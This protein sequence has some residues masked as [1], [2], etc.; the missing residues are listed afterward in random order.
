MEEV[1]KSWNESDRDREKQVAGAAAFNR[2]MDYCNSVKGTPEE[3]QP[4][5]KGFFSK[6][7]KK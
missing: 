6:L 5:P 2:M 3:D 1:I 7:F 4:I